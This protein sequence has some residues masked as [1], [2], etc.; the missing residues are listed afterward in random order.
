MQ[1]SM[2]GGA[3]ARGEHA[4]QALGV[5]GYCAV[6]AELAVL[7]MQGPHERLEARVAEVVSSFAASRVALRRDIGTLD[8][9]A[10]G[11]GDPAAPC[12]FRALFIAVDGLHTIQQAQLLARE[13]TAIGTKQHRAFEERA[14]AHLDALARC[15]PGILTP[16]ARTAS[17]KQARCQYSQHAHGPSSSPILFPCHASSLSKQRAAG[18]A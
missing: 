1:G 7:T 18:S 2:H 13:L 11:D 12:V 3:S 16:A 14:A 10:V 5:G 4:L 6:V 17:S 9:V 8:A 15:V